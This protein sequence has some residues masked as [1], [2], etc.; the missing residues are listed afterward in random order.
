LCYTS[1]AAGDDAPSRVAV[2]KDDVQEPPTVGVRDR[3]DGTGRKP[4]ASS[5]L[6]A[7]SS[8]SAAML[9]GLWCLVLMQWVVMVVF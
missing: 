5:S 3:V 4:E 2:C 1:A 9:T 7:S 6:Q 8:S